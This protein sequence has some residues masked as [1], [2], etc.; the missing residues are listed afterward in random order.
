M[1]AKKNNQI[2]VQ[3]IS[4]DLSDW[5]KKNRQRKYS[6][7]GKERAEFALYGEPQ[8]RSIEIKTPWRFK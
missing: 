1:E 6:G 7:G 3:F 8:N 2:Y 4:K 5:T